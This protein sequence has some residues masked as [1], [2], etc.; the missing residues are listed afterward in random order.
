MPS[1]DSPFGKPYTQVATYTYEE[2]DRLGI[3]YNKPNVTKKSSVV[4]ETKRQAT[5]ENSEA[6][7]ADELKSLS[8]VPFEALDKAQQY[9][10]PGD[11]LPIVFG[12][13]ENNAGGIWISPPLLDSSSDNFVQTFVYLISHGSTPVSTNSNDYF[14]GKECL[15]DITLGASL[16]FNVA[17]SSDPAV[18]PINGY[19]V[20]CD[21][22]NFNFLADP[23]STTVGDFTKIR[24]VNKY[25]TGVT[26]RVKPLY[27]AG[28]SSP[29]AMERY[30]L[31]VYRTDNSTGTTSTVGTIS[32]NAT[33]SITSLSDS[34]SAG[35]YTYSI[36]NTAI[37]TAST[38]KPET[39]LV[40]FRQANTFPTS[41]DRTSS[42]A[43]I[44]LLG[45]QGS[46]YDLTKDYSA[47]TEPKQLHLFMADGI[48]VDKYRYV[49]N[50]I[51]TSAITGTTDSSNFFGD[52]VLYWFQNSGKYRNQNWSYIFPY[53]LATSALFNSHYNITYNA[54]LT[55]S[56]NFLSYAQSIAPMMLCSLVTY[57]GTYAFLPL[58]PLADDG[59]ILTT[60]LTARESFTDSDLDADSIRNSI[61]TGSYS[62]QYKD[63]ESLEPFQVVVTW[64]GQDTFNL[65][66]GQTTVVRYSDYPEDAPEET[67]DMSHFCT[68]ADHA[69]IFAKY[70]LATRR[71]SRHTI[72]F[73]T[74]RNV[75][76]VSG[77]TPLD[78]ISVSLTRT[79]SKGDSRT[80]TEYYLVDSM[81]HT[82]TGLV[83]ITASQFPVDLTGASIISNSIL[84]GSFEVT[85]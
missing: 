20:S 74:A 13:R 75:I 56:T 65:E 17:H 67:Y 23:V 18:C 30:T 73:Q 16:T 44:Q 22:T 70:V 77:L 33:G 81:A 25:A 71:Y 85:T 35:N 27:P 15:T 53:S 31:T 50:S 49:T 9:A 46:L 12:Q 21:H 43:N 38:T 47:P 3:I 72:T 42:Y 51:S 79:N 63:A 78:V 37:L 80:E 39:I 69:A 45:A 58:L 8:L 48:Y 28:A 84:S 61:I 59:Q 10:N 76:A 40:E 24:T 34:M 66:T 11:T 2:A 57:F 54:Y 26:I 4:D 7:R 36:E 82:G 5:K 64:R 1:M 83:E 29:T 41:Y 6:R 55:S 19:A 68:N 52:L 60:A 32:T 62:K 14:F